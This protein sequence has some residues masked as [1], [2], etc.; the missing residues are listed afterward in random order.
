MSFKPKKL[1]KFRNCDGLSGRHV[2]FHHPPF[3]TIED[4]R[5]QLSGKSH[6]SQPEKPP[7]SPSLPSWRNL[8]KKYK[9]FIRKLSP[10]LLFYGECFELFYG[11]RCFFTEFHELFSLKGATEHKNS[12][13]RDETLLATR[14]KKMEWLHTPKFPMHCSLSFHGASFISAFCT[15]NKFS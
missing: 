1:F 13:T 14:K 2:W 6:W 10:I 5:T 15:E 8:A 9:F 3:F 12:F 11:A 4:S 7:E